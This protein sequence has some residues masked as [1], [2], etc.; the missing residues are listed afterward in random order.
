MKIAL[1]QMDVLAGRPEENLARATSLAR[2]AASR[3]AQLLLLPEL[4]LA[5]FDLRHAAEHARAFRDHFQARWAEL[6][7]S[8]G[9]YMAG[10]V[11]AL[12][13]AG[14]AANVALV[15]SPQG[16]VLASYHKVHLFA[17]MQETQ[18]LAPG[19]AAPV[20]DLPWGRTALAVCYDLRFP[21]IFRRF[22]R[23]GA[24][25]VLLPAQWPIPRIEHWRVLLRARAIENLSFV[26][27]CNRAGRNRDGTVFGGRSAV[28]APWGEVLVEAGEEEAL[29]FGKVDLDRVGPL[30]DEFP[31]LA[32]RR[33]ALY[34]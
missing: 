31:F 4:W 9:L 8:T 24:V 30:R 34:R 14:R 23:E 26:V 15:L 19:D 18:Y 22:A 12:D 10:S 5:G 1:A 13:A 16:E 2:E 6:A 17:P 3:G 33:D 27:G 21:E 20:F 11:V 29:L 32:D 28:A 7:V 25:L